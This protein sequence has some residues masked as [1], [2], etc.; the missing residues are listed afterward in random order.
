MTDAKN[1]IETACENWENHSQ[2]PND[3]LGWHAWAEEK[4]KTH[5][6][7]KCEGCGLYKIWVKLPT[8]G[9]ATAKN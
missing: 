3:Y 4:S 7:I 6:Q 1:Y 8:A 2:E 9:G 5:H